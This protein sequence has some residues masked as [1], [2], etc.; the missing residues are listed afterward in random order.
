MAHS[1]PYRSILGNATARLVQTGAVNCLFAHIFSKN[2][3]DNWLHLYDA[4]AATDVSVGT[5]TPKQS[6]AV[7][8]SDDT[9]YVM[10]DINLHDG[11]EFKLGLVFAVTKEADAGATA[12]DSNCIINMGF[13]E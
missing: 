6:Y 7:T 9:H 13:N 10:T 11:L 4:A 3:E 12:P 1:R 5:T 2:N 8:T